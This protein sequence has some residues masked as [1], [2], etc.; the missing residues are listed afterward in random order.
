MNKTE[1]E[2]GLFLFFLNRT[3]A[4]NLQRLLVPWLIAKHGLSFKFTEISVVQQ[5]ITAVID[6]QGWFAGV[7][8]AEEAKKFPLAWTD[9]VTKAKTAA[10]KILLF[11]F[12]IIPCS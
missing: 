4:T 7:P 12:M 9:L 3:N 6:S 5:M 8:C 10:R 1:F 2:L 11:L